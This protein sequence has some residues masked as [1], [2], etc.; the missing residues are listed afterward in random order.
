MFLECL[1]K[2]LKGI[3]VSKCTHHPKRP[4]KF[5]AQLDVN[6]LAASLSREL[7]GGV[8]ETQTR[9]HKIKQA[10]QCCLVTKIC[11]ICHP[12]PQWTVVVKY[13]R[14]HLTLDHQG[15]LITA[16]RLCNCRQ[17][18]IETLSHI[19]AYVHNHL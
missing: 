13:K 10:K 12:I 6:N 2:A 1:E 8:C 17:I 4:K 5:Q 11:L 14:V 9:H 7:N 18:Q 15:S 3:S 16:S 19:G